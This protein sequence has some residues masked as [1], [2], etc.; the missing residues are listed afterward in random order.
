MAKHKRSM[1]G[2]YRSKSWQL[3]NTC[4]LGLYTLLAGLT[5]VILYKNHIL[6]VNGLNWIIFAV[7]ILIFLIALICLISNKLNKLIAVVLILSTLLIGGVLFFAK[8]TVDATK[9]MNESAFY[10]EVEMS[11]IAHKDSALNSISDVTAVEAPV[12]LDRSNIAQLK[13][14]LRES[15]QKELS[16][17]ETESYQTAYETIQ[18]DHSKAMVMNSAYMPLLEQLDQS[19]KDKI[20]TLYTYT[21]RKKSKSQLKHHQSDVMNVYISG[22]DTYGPITTVSRSDVNM[23]MTINKKT[24]KILLTTTPRDSYVK[25]PDG[26]ANQ[27]DK[28]THAGIYGVET[29]EKTLENLYGINIDYYARINFT[30]FMNLID[31][32]GGIE[33][34]NDQAF[35]S[36]GYDFPVGKVSLDSRKALVFARERYQL[37]GGDNDRGKN[38]QKVITA[39]VNKLSSFKTI[40][41]FSGIVNGLSDSIQTNMPT[42]TMMRFANDQIASGG[43]FSVTSQEVTGTGSTGELTSYAMP[44]A[45]LYMYSLDNASVEKAKAE[46]QKIMGESHD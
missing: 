21:I 25:I 17:T 46:I 30:S 23:I 39:I 33:V 2:R 41:N 24:K 34:I 27:F 32:L 31:L 4:L 3:I 5:A 1:N 45:N 40:S 10:S 28:L 9:R 35:S 14:H 37:E 19:V 22:I 36:N 15:D 20:K 8:S 43:R 38:Q 7:W 13:D 42:E 18:A 16:L 12:A 26:G 6:A 11:V 29:S 44:N